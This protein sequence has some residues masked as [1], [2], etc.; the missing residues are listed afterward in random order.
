MFCLLTE[1]LLHARCNNVVLAQPKLCSFLVSLPMCTAYR[2]SRK[3][4]SGRLR[5]KAMGKISVQ[6]MRRERGGW[7]KVR[8][9][10]KEV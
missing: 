7:E 6:A 8:L 9:E 3:A 10:T 4:D 5:W 2:R 1:K